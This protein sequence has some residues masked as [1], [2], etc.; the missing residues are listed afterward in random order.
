MKFAEGLCKTD[1]FY[2]SVSTVRLSE[3]EQPISAVHGNGH[4]YSE[5]YEA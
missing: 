2:L 4:V 3:K 1:S 5:S